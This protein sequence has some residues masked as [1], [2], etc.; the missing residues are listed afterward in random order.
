MI[1]PEVSRDTSAAYEQREV[2]RKRKRIAARRQLEDQDFIIVGFGESGTL[3][4]A[5]IAAGAGIY[6]CVFKKVGEEFLYCFIVDDQNGKTI[7]K[8]IVANH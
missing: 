4:P 7:F 1:K 8:N 5:R 6:K 3:S 2:V